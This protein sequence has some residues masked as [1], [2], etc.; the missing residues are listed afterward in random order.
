MKACSLEDLKSKR[1]ILLS[2]GGRVIALFYHDGKIYAF[3]NRCPHMGFPLIRGTISNGIL[4]CDWHHAR[5]DMESGCTF[6][7]WADDA[8]KYKVDVVDG[9]VWV[10]IEDVRED[11][12]VILGRLRRGLEHGIMLL[13]AKALTSIVYEGRDLGVAYRTAVD[14][15]VSR[16][17][18]WGGG[19]VFI[20][21]I[22]NIKGYLGRDELLMGLLRGLQIVSREART[23]PPRPSIEQLSG[24]RPP[25]DRVK[26]WLTWLTEVRDS[27]ALER[28]LASMAGWGYSLEMIEEAFFEA[29]TMHYLSDGHSVDFANKAFELARSLGYVDPNM[30]RSLAPLLARA[31]RYEEEHEWRHPIDLVAIIDEESSRLHGVTLGGDKPIDPSEVANLVLRD[32]PRSIATSITQLLDNGTSPR[33]ISLGVALAAAIRVARFSRYNDLEDWIRVLHSFSYANAIH[34]VVKRVSTPRVFKGVY[35]AALRVY[36]D[37]YLNEPPYRIPRG[38]PGESRERLLKSLLDT[39]DRRYMIDEVSSI[40]ADYLANG[41]EEEH[42]V[43]TLSH[44]VLREDADFHTVQMLEAGVNLLQ[45]LENPEDRK[46]I[47]IA[48]ARYIASQSPTQRRLKQISQIALKLYRGE[49]IYEE[50]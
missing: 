47:L 33:H 31:S 22:N 40:V 7:L 29:A 34:Q 26:S 30:L 46:T 2:H 43:K 45:E 5:F 9:E 11:Y 18:S 15:Y 17:I 3:D 12:S 28:L 6:D 1:R 44:A 10:N 8:I 50:E 42:L 39:L 41:Y 13:V 36:L 49:R 24:G 21:A 35:H 16:D 25:F 48:M 27:D 14:W 23:E 19:G 20:S 4:T 38:S 32:N 37:R